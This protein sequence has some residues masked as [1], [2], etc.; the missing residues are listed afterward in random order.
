MH[1]ISLLIEG[2]QLESE[3]VIRDAAISSPQDFFFL[4]QEPAVSE[5]NNGANAAREYDRESQE[6]CPLLSFLDRLVA[7]IPLQY[8]LDA[9]A[10]SKAPAM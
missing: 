6:L 4:K 8:L 5:L 7:L 9:E 1:K 10:I 3:E 2:K